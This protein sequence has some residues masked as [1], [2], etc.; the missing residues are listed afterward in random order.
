LALR[1][2]GAKTPISAVGFPWISLDSL[3]RIEPF[4]GVTWIKPPTFFPTPFAVGKRCLK[5]QPTISMA[6]G[7]V[8]HWGKLILFS[9]F[10]QTIVAPAVP[11]WRRGKAREGKDPVACSATAAKTL[12][13]NFYLDDDVELCLLREH[14]RRWKITG[15]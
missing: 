2:Y 3:V 13:V 12:K 10:L 1:R 5:G 11:A 14:D 8:A 6:E 7:R 15:A 9:A 4:Q